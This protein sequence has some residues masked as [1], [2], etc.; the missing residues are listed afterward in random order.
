MITDLLQACGRPT[1]KSMEI[2]IHTI[3]SIGNGCNALGVFIVLPLFLWKVIQVD[4]GGCYWINLLVQTPVDL[5][6]FTKLNLE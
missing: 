1:I 6:R 3:A 2:F 4:I 5:P